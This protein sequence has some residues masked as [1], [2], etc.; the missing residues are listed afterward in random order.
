VGQPTAGEARL[1]NG[2]LGSGVELKLEVT[3]VRVD[4]GDGAARAI[5]QAALAVVGCDQ[6]PVASPV[7]RETMS[8]SPPRRPFAMSSSR[9]DRLSAATSLRRAARTSTFSPESACWR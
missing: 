1:V 9:I 2:D 8:S 5:E 4:G 3:A 6:D 7:R